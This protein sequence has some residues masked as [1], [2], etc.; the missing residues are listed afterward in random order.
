MTTPLHQDFT[1]SRG[2]KGYNKKVE[3]A[4]QLTAD[5][6]ATMRYPSEAMPYLEIMQNGGVDMPATVRIALVGLRVS[7]KMQGAH[8][9]KESMSEFIAM[10]QPWQQADMDVEFSA[11]DQGTWTVAS[12]SE[13]S[14]MNRTSFF[15]KTVFTEL[16]L[17]LIGEGADKAPLVEMIAA[18][19]IQSW[20][21]NP[22]VALDDS[23]MDVV[24]SSLR[25][26]RVLCQV[27]CN[28]VTKTDDDGWSD[29]AW[30]KSLRDSARVCFEVQ[31]ALAINENEW[32]QQR[33]D[34]WLSYKDAIRRHCVQLEKDLFF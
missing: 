7:S 32:W 33:L 11:T 29:L 31:V 16:L 3:A 4:K 24:E 22:E 5:N 6:I 1:P 20:E 19:C 12:L 18:A 14:D 10:C 9:T 23:A 8:M 25:T 17:P 34:L 27:V 13:V 28:D 2:G 21:A 30:M 26:W 15:A